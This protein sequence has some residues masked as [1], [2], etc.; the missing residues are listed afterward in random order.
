[1][2]GICGILSFTDDF[3]P[4]NAA[5]LAMRDTL[6]HRGPDDA[7]IFLSDR[8]GLAMRR[9]SIV[10][11]AG[12]HQPLF[13]E[14]GEI[15]IVCNGEIYNYRSL[16]EE[17]KA[18]GHHFRSNSDTEV[19]VHLYEEM[20]CECLKTL[21]GM[22]AFAIWDGRS[23]VLFM[24]RDRL[25]EKPLVYSL[26]PQGLVFGSEIS[27]ILASPLSIP[28]ALD[29]EAISGYLT[30]MTV[31]EPLTVLRAVRKLPAGHY[32]LCTGTGRV[33]LHQ[34]W[35]VT[36]WD[37]DNGR[38]E[39]SYLEELSGL[40]ER[41]VTERLIG[42][43]PIGAFLSGGVDSSVITAIMARATSAPVK[44]FS[45]RFGG[46]RY[47]DETPF[48]RQV[49]SQYQTEHR[50]I[51]FTPRV[52][53]ELARIVSC[54]G[55]PYAVPS[56]LAVYYMSKL[57]REYVKVVLTGDGGDE[58]FA[59]YQR[60]WWEAW[61]R[62]LGLLPVW[63]AIRRLEGLAAH[64]PVSRLGHRISKLAR[65]VN[66]P[67]DERY[68][69]AFLACFSEEQKSVL[70]DPE[71]WGTLS[72][73][74]YDPVDVLRQHYAR[75]PKLEGLARRQYGDLKSTLASEMLT[76]TDS[77]TM[78]ASLEARPPLLDYQ[79]VEFAARLPS[80]LKIGCR[81][82]KH[83][84]KRYAETCL[85]KEIVRRRKHGFAVP[86]DSWFRGELRELSYEVLLSSAA[87]ARGLFNPR[88]VARLLDQHAER[89]G[90]F[91]THIY[92]MLT[93]ELW[94]QANLDTATRPMTS[95][96]SLGVRESTTSG[97]AK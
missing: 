19:I 50:E 13:N 27:A 86:L 67:Q 38:T 42:D 74:D 30:Y 40:L 95:S 52:A 8:I 90:N 69:A 77:M 87:R 64:A 70:L 73:L 78:A 53:D 80:G 23:G 34:Y 46:S 37:C 1:M 17:L 33:A 59:G 57:A 72:A 22:F 9:L 63:G 36:K 71:T 88:A 6:T 97:T 15:A 47:Y 44:T 79:L 31:P 5:L 58:V 43:V 32:L 89:V 7:G 84:L 16:R 25:G 76:K 35:D 83:L 62:W 28:R 54:V 10:D 92:V 61:M 65:V 91:G 45:V 21:D 68:M 55:Q 48:A 96:G 26:Q 81:G 51:S 18:K 75:L 24:A 49:A 4:D 82:G 12:G 11:L 2:C 85:P 66:L 93:L 29:L 39:A 41:A 60:Y 94:C 3:R 20:G 56:G 14:T